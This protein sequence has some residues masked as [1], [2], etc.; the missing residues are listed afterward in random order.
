MGCF[1]ASAPAPINY[2]TQLSDTLNSQ[3]QLAPQLYGTEAQYQPM[4]NSLALKNINTM[5][6]GQAAGSMNVT[7]PTTAGQTGWYDPSG[8]FI[9]T[10]TVEQSVRQPNI[11]GGWTRTGPNPFAPAAGGAPWPGPPPQAGAVWRNAGTQ[12][13]TTHSVAT[14]ATPGLQQILSQANTQTR[15]ANMADVANLGPAATNAVQWA[16]PQQGQL[17]DMMNQQ[18]QQGLAYGSN[19]TPDEQTAMQQASRAAFA[20]RG[21][22]GSN[23]ELADELLK[24]FNLGQSL[25]QQRQN[26]A[27]NVAGYNNAYVTSPAWQLMTAQSPA[28]G[29][30][31][32]VMANAGP[33]LFNPQSPLAGSIAAGNQ[34]MA[35]AFAD[36]STMSK[37]GSVMGVT[38]QLVGGIAGGMAM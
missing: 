9:G 17:I 13:D 16:D 11:H 5:L 1:G 10:G 15:Q 29:T 12:Y 8:K 7:G 14:P 4:Y 23:S 32:G 20:A 30:A 24:Q 38:G 37:I 21:M 33:G 27:G 18:A 3:I 31:Q 36:P 28:F 26:F 25:L 22:T 35:A 2:G 34:Q 6:N 19:L